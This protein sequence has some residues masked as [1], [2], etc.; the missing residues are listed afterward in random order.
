[1]NTAAT[2]ASPALAQQVRTEHPIWRTSVLFTV[3]MTVVFGVAYPLA[4]TL[5]AKTLFPHKAAGSLIEP[6]AFF[7]KHRIHIAESFV[8]IQTALSRCATISEGFP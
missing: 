7:F 2:L 8:A 5:V 4:L 6:S 3:I 1:M